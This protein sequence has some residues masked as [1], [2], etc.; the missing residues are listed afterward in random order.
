MGLERQE[1]VKLTID[2]KVTF[3]SVLRGLKGLPSRK[4]QLNQQI[5]SQYDDNGAD[6]QKYTVIG[7]TCIEREPPDNSIFFSYRFA[8]SKCFFP[9]V[10]TF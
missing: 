2:V 5:N 3:C 6:K 9:P 7:F 10:R 1:K 4:F 8:F